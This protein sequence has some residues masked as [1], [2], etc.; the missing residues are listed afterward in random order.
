VNELFTSIA[1]LMPLDQL[2]DSSRRRGGARLNT[3]GVDLNNNEN[4]SGCACK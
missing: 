4:A 2:A 3:Q 1:K